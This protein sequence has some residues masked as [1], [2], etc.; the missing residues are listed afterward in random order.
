MNNL[1]QQLKDLHTTR[2]DAEEQFDVRSRVVRFMLAHP[3]SLAVRNPEV[4]R[5]QK[6]GEGHTASSLLNS[7]D[8]KTM[9][10][11]ILGLIFALGGGVSY[12]AERSLPGDTLYPVKI[13]V[14]ENVEGAFHV[15]AAADADFARTQLE[16]RAEE[17]KALAAKNELDAEAKSAVIVESRIHINDYQAAQAEMKAEGKVESARHSEEG[18]KATTEIYHDAFLDIG[19]DLN[20]VLRADTLVSVGGS[21]EAEQ[22]GAV[23]SS[24]TLD[25]T[26][27]ARTLNTTTTEAKAQQHITAESNTSVEVKADGTIAAPTVLMPSVSTKASEGGG[28]HLGL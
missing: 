22:R 26:I 19:L 27:N 14:N 7:K 6:R 20:N 17:A 12:A 2:L 28:L 4:V 9:M 10:T 15:G 21:I 11:I 3:A 13:H 5:H 25:G 23:V 16:R 18:M 1:E 24:S 8:K